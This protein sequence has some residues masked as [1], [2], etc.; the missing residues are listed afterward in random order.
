MKHEYLVCITIAIIIGGTALSSGPR[1]EQVQTLFSAAQQGDIDKIKALLAE[2][3]DVNKANP[4]GVTTLHVA[5]S[6]GRREVCAFLID[7]GAD[8]N[9]QAMRDLTPLHWATMTRREKIVD[10]LI[11]KGAD[12]NAKDEKGETALDLAASSGISII[13]GELL[14]K[15]GAEVSSPYAAAYLGDLIRVRAFMKEGVDVNQKVGMMQGTILHSAAAGGHKEIMKFLISKGADVNAQNRPGQT[16][17]HIAAEN[18]YV[19][20]VILLLNNGAEAN[21]KD[22]RDK[23]PLDLAVK[24]NHNDI[25]NVLQKQIQVHDVAVT[26]LSAPAIC[27]KGETVRICVNVENLGDYRES[28]AIKLSNTTMDAEIGSRTMT[29]RIGGKANLVFDPPTSGR[30]FFGNY[31]YHG[32]INGDGYDDLLIAAS[33][34]DEIRGRAYLYYGGNDMDTT[35]DLVFT[36]E[37]VGDYFSEGAWLSDLNGDGYCDVILGALG[38]NN[39][40]GKVYVFYGGPSVDAKVDMIFEGERNIVGNFGRTCCTGDVNGDGYEDLFVGANR[41]NDD[42]TGRVYLYYGGE[43]MDTEVDLILTGENPGDVFGWMIDSSGDVDGDGFCDLVVVTRWWPKTAQS[44]GKA[45]G[46]GYLYYGGNPMDG[47]CDVIFT[48]EQAGD[49][50]GSGLEVADVDGDGRAEIFIAARRYNNSTGRVYA[51]WGKERR[52]WNNRPDLIFDGECPRSSFG[53]DDIEVGDID[54]DG[55][56]DI[57]IAAYSYPS[58]GEGSSG[59]GR[60]YLYKGNTLGQMNVDYDDTITFSRKGNLAMFMT[61]GDFDNDGYGDLVVGGW[62]YPEDSCQGRA[63]LYYGDPSKCPAVTFTWDT[64]NASVGKHTLK[65]EIPPVPGEQNTDDNVKTVTVEVKEPPR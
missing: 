56:K 35:P 64:T 63:W 17:L 11:V 61:I 45:M 42:Y 53:G 40:Q 55:Y 60:I 47:V 36:G 6:A 14:A 25:I 2:G 27:I 32:D 52:L 34:F 22:R 20:V 15:K 51:Y 8:I 7:N 57:S 26:D 1:D 65:V 37:T 46:R 49:E 9:A 4:A 31:V 13:I 21:A 16:P 28:T 48:G 10:L 12:V 41:Y 44:G 30:Q 5:A 38:H 23:T 29:L 3:I 33:R 18:G 19:D 24:A 39:K 62:G 43:S 58:W 50:L 54:A 59:N